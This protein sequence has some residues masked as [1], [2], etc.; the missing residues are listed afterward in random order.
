VFNVSMCFSLA[1]QFTNTTLT[2]GPKS[3]YHDTIRLCTGK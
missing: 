1:Q 2:C 3:T